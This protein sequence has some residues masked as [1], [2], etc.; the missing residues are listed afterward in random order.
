MNYEYK[1]KEQ[2]LIRNNSGVR[3]VLFII[4]LNLDLQIDKEV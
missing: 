1:L 4:L 2:S 3:A